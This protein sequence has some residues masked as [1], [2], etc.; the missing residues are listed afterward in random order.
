MRPRLPNKPD[1]LDRFFLAM[2]FFIAM[3]VAVVGCHSNESYCKT[4]N[5]HAI[6][7]D[8]DG[9]A[10]HCYDLLQGGN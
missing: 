5:S 2:A 1:G 8:S 6:D 9:E 7:M 4:T 10:V 3:C